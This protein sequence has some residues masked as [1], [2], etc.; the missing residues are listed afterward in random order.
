[1]YWIN[2]KN[3]SSDV[4]VCLRSIHFHY[5]VFW[6]WIS[7]K[8]HLYSRDTLR[9]LPAWSLAYNFYKCTVHFKSI[10]KY[11]QHSCDVVQ[12][13]CN[14]IWYFERKHSFHKLASVCQ[15]ESSYMYHVLIRLN[16]IWTCVWSISYFNS[17]FS[18]NSSTG[19]QLLTF[20][21]HTHVKGELCTRISCFLVYMHWQCLFVNCCKGWPGFNC[22]WTWKTCLFFRNCLPR[23]LLLIIHTEH[24]FN[25]HVVESVV[26]DKCYMH[27]YVY[28]DNRIG[29]S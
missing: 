23:F 22:L 24:Q 9:R 21:I 12:C 8:F 13:V 19:G 11:M 28:C 4:H 26:A 2:R 15:M 7:L 27:A 29:F 17:P 14:G 3:A 10:H 1:M 18:V 5:F 6:Y 16:H 20:A 25:I